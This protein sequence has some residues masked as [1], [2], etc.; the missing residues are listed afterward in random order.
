MRELWARYIVVTTGVL[1]VALAVVFAW[2]QNP[3]QKPEITAPVSSPEAGSDQSSKQIQAGRKV[4][5]QQG[6]AGCH[7]I[8]GKG[9]P[10][11]TLDGV[12]NRRSKE[13]IRNWIVGADVLKGQASAGILGLKQQ[14]KELAD[15]EL[16]ALVTY[17]HSLR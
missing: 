10:R 1:V 3:S 16:A 14:Y 5:Q 12:G 6:C 4:Y 13:E 11:N 15:D 8:A 17:L 7:A 9:N 2:A